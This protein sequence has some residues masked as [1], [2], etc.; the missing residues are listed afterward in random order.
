ML[1]QKMMNKLNLYLVMK[2]DE[3]S[4][5]I[6]KKCIQ[7]CNYLLPNGTKLSYCKSWLQ[8]MPFKNSYIQFT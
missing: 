8:C 6:P 1:E 4:C 7:I 5:I 3:Y 2:L